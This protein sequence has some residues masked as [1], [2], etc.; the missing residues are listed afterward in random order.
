MLT[1]PLRMKR[2]SQFN[3]TFKTGKYIQKDCLAIVTNKKRYRDQK[4]GIV[5]N[6]KIGNSVTRNRT[7]RLL[8]EAIRSNLE[9]IKKD[10]DIIL[11]ARIGIE[12][13]DYAKINSCLKEL[14]KKSNVLIV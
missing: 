12:Q 6:K 13:W 10:I 9:F 5:V 14:L 11:V 4:I 7:K 3:Y 8:R 1:K 2:N